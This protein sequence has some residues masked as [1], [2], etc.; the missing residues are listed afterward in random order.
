MLL[1]LT[2]HHPFISDV[3]RGQLSFCYPGRSEWAI[4][5][6]SLGIPAG[7][8]VALVGGSG[9][10]K[11]TLLSLLM[12]WLYPSHGTISLGEQVCFDPRAGDFEK[13]ARRLRKSIS[14]VFQDFQKDER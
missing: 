1:F 7:K 13:S 14:V 10:G 8:F 3:K 9:C 5:D 11:T 6:V 4:N 12:T 2:M